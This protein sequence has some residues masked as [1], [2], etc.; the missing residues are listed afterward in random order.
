LVQRLAHLLRPVEDDHVR[1]LEAGAHW[2]WVDSPLD[3]AQAFAASGP[4][5][6]MPGPKSWIFTSATLGD[7]EQLNWFAQPLGLAHAQ[8]A[9][10]ASPFDFAAQAA[11]WVPKDLPMPNE[12]GHPLVLARRIAPWVQRLGGRTMV[13]TTSLR[14]LNIIAQELREQLKTDAVE[15]LVQ[16][17][18]SK[19]ELLERFRAY[20]DGARARNGEASAYGGAVLVASV[21]FWEGV[22]VPGDALQLVV[23]DKLP[24]PVPDDPLTQARAKRLQAAGQSP[25]TAQVLPDTAVALKQGAGRLIRAE[26][27]KGVL[28]IGDQRLVTMGYGKRLLQA[29]PP[30]QRLAS[31]A[32]MLAYLDGLLTTATTTT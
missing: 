24:F 9:V 28:V 26:S 25:F 10:V 31:E 5:S 4:D 6:D 14:A 20:A 15:V 2:R 17:E 1:W 23:L 3:S 29:M 18:L 27:D 11:L 12:P 13:L 32:D 19:N 22:D 16:G 21:S 7:D 30:M 8:R